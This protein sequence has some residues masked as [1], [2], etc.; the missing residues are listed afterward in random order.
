MA[1]RER[2]RTLRPGMRAPA[3]LLGAYLL[4][5]LFLQGELAKAAEQNGR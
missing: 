5:R 1:R 2:L 4:T 3:A